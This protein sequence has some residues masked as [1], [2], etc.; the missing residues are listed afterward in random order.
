MTGNGMTRRERGYLKYA[1]GPKPVQ[2]VEGSY[3][4]T[5]VDGKVRLTKN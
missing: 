4:Y 5:G 1:D 2:V 3:S